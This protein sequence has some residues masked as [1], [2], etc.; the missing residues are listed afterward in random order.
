M[1]DM[2][3][4]VG[5]RGSNGDDSDSWDPVARHQKK[6]PGTAVVT[7]KILGREGGKLPSC[8]K[9]I[10]AQRP[11]TKSFNPKGVGILPFFLET[12]SK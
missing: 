1:Y 5:Q 11:Q 2:R 4:T 8:T 6:I 10:G 12:L 3:T 7:V 9:E